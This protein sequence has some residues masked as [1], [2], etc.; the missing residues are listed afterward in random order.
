MLAVFTY[1]NELGFEPGLNSPEVIVSKVSN[2]ETRRRNQET[3]AW[4]QRSILRSKLKIVFES[5]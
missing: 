1:A 2:L 3:S 4:Q 5:R